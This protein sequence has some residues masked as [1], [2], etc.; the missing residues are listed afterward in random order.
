[1]APSHLA[2]ISVRGLRKDF[3]TRDKKGRVT[4]T[5]TALDSIDLD[6]DD[7]QF[8][9]VVGPSGCGKSTL[10]DML[11][12]LAP[13]T[14]GEIWIDGDPVNGASLDRGVVFQ[15]YALFP[16]LSALDNV[17]FALEAKGLSKAERHEVAR[18]YLSIVG[19]DGFDQRYPHQL[20]GGMKQ[21]VALAR[22]LAHDPSVL[23]M[24]EPFAALDAQTREMLQAEL[25]RIWEKSGKTVVFI[26]HGID[27]AIYLSQKIAVMTSRPGRIKHIIDNP[28]AGAPAS[29]D[30]RASPEF[31]RLRHEVWTL[32]RDEV[33]HAAALERTAV[34]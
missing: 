28:L 26:T 34:Y 16:W 24:D 23:L 19:L 12:G 15:Q 31:G 14:A 2:K 27:E 1:M 10:L 9:T 7:G 5:F 13:P 29:D 20:S 4:G 33:S 18:E 8:I 25:L 22:S 17:A 30:I 32:L 6:I 11:G 21:R 3:V